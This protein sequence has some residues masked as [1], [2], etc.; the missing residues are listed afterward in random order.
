MSKAK[1]MEVIARCRN[2]I[3]FTL[4]ELLVVISIVALLISLLLPALKKAKE[5]AR[6]VQCLSNLHQLT[7]ALHVY[8]AEEDGYFPPH[9]PKLGPLSTFYCTS[10]WARTDRGYFWGG[11]EGWSGQGLLFANSIIDDPQ[12]LYCPSQRFPNFTYPTGWFH[13]P[14]AGYHVSGYYYRLFS[15]LKQGVT[16]ADIDRLHNY[17]TSDLEKPLTLTSDIFWPGSPTHGPYPE[18]TAW[19]HLEPP[20]LNATYSDGHGETIAAPRLFGYA[21]L[22]LAIYGSTDRFI[23][24]FWEAL[25]GDAQRLEISYWLPP[26]MLE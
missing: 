25:D 5:S 1:N 16:Q 15:E 19:P 11:E 8:T 7:N 13:A 6:V 2:C 9:H 20:I 10:P 23:M 21:Q 18:D 22:G 3:G 4:I 24:M 14:W 26:D 17:R 12:F